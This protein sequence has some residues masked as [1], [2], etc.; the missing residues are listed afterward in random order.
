MEQR[1]N[2]TDREKQKDSEKNLSQ[3]HF[4]HHKS[5][6]ALGANRGLRGKKLATNRLSYGTSNNTTYTKSI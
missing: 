4:V 2:D 5:H 6:P 3:H 1:W